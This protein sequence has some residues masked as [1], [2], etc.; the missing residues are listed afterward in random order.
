MGI[1]LFQWIGLSYLLLHQ[2]SYDILTD[3]GAHGPAAVVTL[4]QSKEVPETHQKQ[5]EVEGFYCDNE[6]WLP[7]HRTLKIMH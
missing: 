3:D 1:I 5:N 7:G 4:M 6:N 2:L